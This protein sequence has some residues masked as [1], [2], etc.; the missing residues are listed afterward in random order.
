MSQDRSFQEIISNAQSVISDGVYHWANRRTNNERNEKY[1]KLVSDRDALSKSSQ[2]SSGSIETA[3]KT[4]SGAVLTIAAA[5]YKDSDGEGLITQEFEVKTLELMLEYAEYRGFDSSPEELKERITDRDDKLH[6]LVQNEITT[7]EDSL[8]RVRRT[9][10]NELTDAEYSFLTD[11]YRQR[12]SN[13]REAVALYVQERG[14]TEVVNDI[15]Q[16]ALAAGDSATTRES[17]QEKLR[18]ELRSFEAEIRSGLREQTQFIQQQLTESPQ[19]D[20]GAVTDE[21]TESVRKLLEEHR[22]RKQKL[23]RVLD[24]VEGMESTLNNTHDE[25]ED[26][27]RKVGQKTKANDILE[28]ELDHVREDTAAVKDGIDRMRLEQQ[29]LAAQIEELEE[30]QATGPET[31]NLPNPIGEQA[32]V[33]SVRSSVA[34]VAELDFVNRFRNALTERAT[35]DLPRGGTTDLSEGYWSNR[36]ES[37]NDRAT[38]RDLVGSDQEISDYPQNERIRIDASLTKFGVFTSSDSLLFEARSLSHLSTFAEHGLDWQPV[39]LSDLLTELAD[40]TDTVSSLKSGGTRILAIGSPTGWT[41]QAIEYLSE[42]R[43]ILGPSL[44][45]C[46]V[47][48]DAGETHYDQSDELMQRYHD[49]F[50]G[51]LN[52]DQ[53]PACTSDIAEEYAADSSM[54]GVPLSRVVD[55]LGYAP[56]I[57]RRAFTQLEQDGNGQRQRGKSGELLFVFE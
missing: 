7:Q 29:R 5:D 35:L 13:L 40:L 56:H 47:D 52:R 57:V 31:S 55:D 41:D 44:R 16:A 15:E 48:L 37:S 32:A 12:R 50:T 9:Q 26:V 53:I 3:K 4:V 1:S 24:E 33:D 36:S 19:P 28:A 54:T 27:Q 14:V 39:T 17:V 46:L 8:Q 45:V 25:L 18:E 34:R 22:E 23:D 42:E 20:R 30:Q 38:V 21:L 43:A 51:T 49:L 10:H 6:G 2:S 11:L